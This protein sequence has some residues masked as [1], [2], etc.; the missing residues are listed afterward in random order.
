MKLRH[1][2]LLLCAFAALLL[3]ATPPLM[4]QE[5]QEPPDEV[6][7]NNEGY[8]Q[9]KKGPVT[10][11]HANHV[12]LYEVSCEECHHYYIDEDGVWNDWAEGEPINKCAACHPA[13]GS[14][15]DAKSLLIAY[16]RNCIGCHREVVKEGISEDA[17]Q[18]RCFDCHEKP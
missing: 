11:S 8:R 12:D 18:R 17:P 9:D 13:T 4:A 2:M 5:A 14:T 16:H 6:V 7:I 15:E 10:L 1:A 3:F